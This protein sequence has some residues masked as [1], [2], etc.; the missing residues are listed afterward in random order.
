M[1]PQSGDRKSKKSLETDWK[2]YLLS[3]AV[4]EKKKPTSKLSGLK[5][6]PLITPG[7]G[8]G[9]RGKLSWDGSSL[10]PVVLAR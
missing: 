3:I 2:V 4:E 5:Q 1:L 9:N 10:L 7:S 6:Q 8:F